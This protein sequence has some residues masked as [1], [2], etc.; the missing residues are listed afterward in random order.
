MKFL[1]FLMSLVVLTTAL[2]AC[3]APPSPAPAQL[4][5]QDSGAP[6]A[7]PAQASAIVLEV[8]PIHGWQARPSLPDL[9]AADLEATTW[10]APAA[11][12]FEL[13]AP[14]QPAVELRA[15]KHRAL[16]RQ[17]HGP[18]AATAPATRTRA[19]LAALW[20]LS[21]KL[22]LPQKRLAAPRW[23]SVRQC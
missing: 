1:L 11:V 6:A 3:H 5:Q 20:S 4:Q 9:A 2:P 23:S 13:Q 7:L 15:L 8:A 10:G 16:E 19:D 22:P 12:Q 17:A 18:I 14:E 21:R